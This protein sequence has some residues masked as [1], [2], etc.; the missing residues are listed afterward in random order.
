VSG[1]G[2]SEQSRNRKRCAIGVTA[3]RFGGSIQIIADDNAN[4][5][6]FHISSQ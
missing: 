3:D 2:K 6:L 4:L 5:A 1:L